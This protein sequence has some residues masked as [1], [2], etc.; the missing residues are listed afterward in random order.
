[1][2]EGRQKEDRGPWIFWYSQPVLSS[3]GEDF[4]EEE[5]VRK[6]PRDVDDVR[7]TV[8]REDSRERVRERTESRVLLLLLLL[9]L[10]LTL[11]L[12]LTPL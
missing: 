2:G 11:T 8:V 3:E 9:L 7:R 5:E 4:E 12:P 6:K 1:M 10:L